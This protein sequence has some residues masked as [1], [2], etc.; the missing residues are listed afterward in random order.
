M[1]QTRGWANTLLLEYVILTEKAESPYRAFLFQGLTQDAKGRKMSKSLGNVIEANK[2]LD[3]Y[4]AD[5]FR[6]YVLRKC[7]PIDPNDFD[8]KEMSR[9]PYQVLSTLYHLSRFLAQNSEFDRFDPE[10]HTLESA[11]REKQLKSPDLWLLSRLQQT[12]E[13]YTEKLEACE[14][15]VA[16]AALEDAVIEDVSRLYVPM[17]RKELWT[18]DPETLGRRLAV[19]STLWHVLKTITLL[20]NPVTPYL[21]EALYQGVYRK[22]DP[23]LPETVNLENWPKPNEELR[24]KAI[25]ED[26]QTLFSVVSLV[27]SA[28]QNVKLKRRWPLSR[29]VIVASEKIRKALK[30]VED[31]LL[32]LTNVKT[33]E[34]IE[35]APHYVA[36]E[37]WASASESDT[38]VFLDVHRDQK[39]LGEGLMRDLARR[40]QALRKELGYVPSDVLDA[41]HIAELDQ[42]T[43]QLLQPYL[44]EMKELTRAKNIHLPISREETETEWHESQLDE[45]KVYIAI[46]AGSKKHAA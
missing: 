29:M 12:I 42:E 14:F 16:L 10:K 26:F 1:D 3:T 21:S 7:P 30:N 34:Y 13:T 41:V 28:R 31:L 24:V 11:R 35:K 39:L 45:K 23:T 22:L 46:H 17:V 19:Y 2:A 5:V 32:E 15:N 36:E 4:S 6:F 38:E 27:Y 33:V 25:E 9:R 37:G 18:D 43:I 44:Q 20:F 40:V 8:P